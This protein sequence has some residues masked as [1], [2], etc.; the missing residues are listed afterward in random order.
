LELNFLKEYQL[1]VSPP[2]GCARTLT[3][4]IFSFGLIFVSLRDAKMEY[5]LATRGAKASKKA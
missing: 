5:L 3:V 4:S 1:P 2:H